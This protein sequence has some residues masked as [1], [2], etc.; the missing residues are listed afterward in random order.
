M[1]DASDPPPDAPRGDPAE[2][3]MRF[4]FAL[5]SHGVTDPRVLA[6]MDSHPRIQVRL[7]NAI[8]WRRPIASLPP[9]CTLPPV[10][11]SSPA[12]AA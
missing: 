1:A 4:L 7:F 5:R 2:R 9:T 10:G 8:S 12:S 11:G 6:A 3:Q